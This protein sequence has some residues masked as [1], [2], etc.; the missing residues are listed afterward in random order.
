[1]MTAI[2]ASCRPRST[3]HSASLALL[4]WL[5]WEERIISTFTFSAMML[6]TAEIW[7]QSRSAYETEK[8]ADLIPDLPALICPSSKVLG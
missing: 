1:M 5:S 7:K 6:L 8:H 4:C 3:I 2:L